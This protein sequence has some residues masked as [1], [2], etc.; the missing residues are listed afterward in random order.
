MKKKLKII[1]LLSLLLISLGN[2]ATLA[3]KE[4]TSE[5]FIPEI[6]Y[7]EFKLDN[8]LEIYVL[9]DHQ[10]PLVNFSVWYKV[11]SID[12]RD[13][14]SGISHLLEHTM[15]LGTETLNKGQI[16]NLVKSVG[17]SN[18]AGTFYDY[19]KYYEELPSSKLELAMAIE[20]DRMRNLAINPQ[21]FRR[22]KK[23]VKQERRKRVENS[24]FWSSLEEVQSKAWANTPLE[25]QI[26][27]WME[28]L[29]QIDLQNMKDY[30]RQYYA[31]NNA[32]L[33]VSGDVKPQQVKRL[34]QKYY[35]D[36]QAQKIE[37]IQF[38]KP[39]QKKEQEVTVRK[40]TRVPFIQMIYPIPAA[41]DEDIIAIKALMDIL[42][43]NSSSRVKEHLKQKQRLILEAGSNVQGLRKE[44]FALLYLI[45]TSEQLVDRVRNSF[46]HQLQR[47]KRKGITKEELEI[48]KKNSLKTMIFN[49]RDTGTKANILAQG[50]VRFDNPEL[51]K[52]Q[53]STLKNLTEAD[54]VAAAK[55]YFKQQDRTIGYILPKQIVRQ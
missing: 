32:A 36:Y 20:S 48:V 21:E 38:A 51:Y 39:Q 31:P 16:H 40:V 45:P 15:F 13:G 33:V 6:N 11:G 28:D 25:H 53:L 3:Q 2:G 18:N 42:V 9:E 55:K 19:T 47:I 34:A 4:T 27:G 29:N 26:I 17:G 14:I 54:I 22:E 8:G 30:Y 43:N 1:I 5:V 50:V 41:N 44:G 10:L 35:G 37:R 46:D 49:Q 24:V 7:T 52:E 12:E 23:V